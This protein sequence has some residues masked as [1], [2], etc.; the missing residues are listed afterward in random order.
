M[1]DAEVVNIIGVLDFRR[2]LDLSAVADLLQS[3]NIVSE[4]EYSPE[5]NHWL[6]TRFKLDGEKKYVAFY[7]S[8]SS[9]LVGCSSFEQLNNLVKLVKSAME[10]VIQKPPLLEIK[11][12]VFVGEINQEIN[13]NELAIAAGLEQVEYEPEQF[14]GLIYRD[15]QSGTVFLVFSSG[16]IIHTG[17]GT[18]KEANQSFQHFTKRMTEWGI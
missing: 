3:S 16:K 6:Q 5:K 1:P 14:P 17:S 2:E 7:R 10:P 8:G 12:L 9:A 4:V 11:N 15:D 13:L 18:V